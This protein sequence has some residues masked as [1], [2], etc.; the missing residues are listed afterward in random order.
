MPQMPGGGRTGREKKRAVRKGL[1][2]P[3]MKK[4]KTGVSAAKAAKSIP[5]KTLKKASKAAGR[6]YRA[7]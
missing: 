6:K 2:V 5:A 3:V 4:A 1:P 7:L